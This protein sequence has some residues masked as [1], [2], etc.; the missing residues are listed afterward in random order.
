MAVSGIQ[1]I[2]SE[3][4]L[5]RADVVPLF[6]QMSGE[7]IAQV[8]GLLI[9]AARTASRIAFWNRL[10]AWT[11]QRVASAVV[12][13][14]LDSSLE[15]HSPLTSGKERKAAGKMDQRQRPGIPELDTPINQ[16]P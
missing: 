7:R 9:P 5:N 15:P 6:H 8:S 2:V 1:V 14:D 16:E 11:L 10:G 3:M 13:L 12:F 4:F